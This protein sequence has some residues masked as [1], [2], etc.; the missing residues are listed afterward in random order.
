MCPEGDGATHHRL[1]SKV[2]R[3]RQTRWCVCL[4]SPF[5]GSRFPTPFR[6]SFDAQT[7]PRVPAADCQRRECALSRFP[8]DWLPGCVCARTGAPA[9]GCRQVCAC[10]RW[11][12]SVHDS[13]V[14]GD[15]FIVLFC[16]VER[17]SLP[18]M[19]RNNVDPGGSELL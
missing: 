17:C 10:S 9:P 4:E 16:F 14:Y 11:H 7:A 19:G 2:C 15:L 6:N 8:A 18:D 5:S 1:F 12:G 13:K 3:D